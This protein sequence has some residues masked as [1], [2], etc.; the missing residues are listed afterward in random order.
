MVPVTVLATARLERYAISTHPNQDQQKQRE[1]GG[2]GHETSAGRDEEGRRQEG[3]TFRNDGNEGATVARAL[4]RYDGGAVSAGQGL[5]GRQEGAAGQQHERT[6]LFLVAALL[7]SRR[8][9]LLHRH[10]RPRPTGL[11]PSPSLHQQFHLLLSLL[12]YVN[13]KTLAQHRILSAPVM[14]ATTLHFMYLFNLP[15]PPSSFTSLL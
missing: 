10:R 2:H 9:P 13:V 12:T 6:V 15:L 7:A 14:D 11:L 8:H 4:G 3:G 5:L 1:K